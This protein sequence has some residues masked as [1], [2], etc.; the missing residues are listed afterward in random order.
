[1]LSFKEITKETKEEVIDS[2]SAE[3]DKALL[4]EIINGFS[5]SSD[6]EFALSVC[7]GCILVRVFDMGKYVFLYPYEVSE[8]SDISDAIL[9]ISRYAMREEIPLVFSDVPADAL[10]SFSIFRHMDIDAEDAYGES[11]SVKIKTECML[12]NQIPTVDEGRVKLSPIFKDD[13]SLYAELSKS[14]NVNKYW[15]YNY[16]NDVASP[17]DEYFYEIAMR[18][19]DCG[20]AMSLAVRCE[21]EFA[22]EAVIYAFDGRGGAEFAIRL[23]PK[24]QGQG[25]GRAGVRAISKLAAQIGLIRLHSVIMKENKRSIAMLDFFT[26]IKEDLGDSFRYTVELI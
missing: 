23:L 22:G 8:D 26:D 18:E 11:F 2:L 12:L 16:E 7:A 3:V 9:E 14:Q 24:W 1:M 6:L 17:S 13:I 20:V 21:G 5:D 10:S 15:G 4:S 25:L 19:F